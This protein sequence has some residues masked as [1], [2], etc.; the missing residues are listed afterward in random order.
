MVLIPHAIRRSSYTVPLVAAVG[1]VS[2]SAAADI[3]RPPINYTTAT[4]DNC[5]SRLERRIESGQTRLAF[6]EPFGYLPSLLRE[7]EIAPSSQMLVFSKTSF[8][9]QRISPEKPRAVYFNDEAYVGYCQR[10]NVVEVTAVDPQLGAV[11][12]TLEQK[13]A[14]RPRFVRQ[15]DSCLIC[16]ASSA[17]QGFP[18]HLVRSVYADADG[19]PVLSLGSHR[20]N[21]CSPLSERWGGWYVTGA[22]GKQAHLGNLIVNEERQPDRIDNTAGL[23]VTDLSRRFA[24]SKY[25]SPHS[26]IV[27]LMVFEHQTE[28]QNLIARANFLAKLALYE[29]ADLNKAMGRPL[30]QRSES[31]TR[32]LK[33]AAEPLVQYMLFSGESPLT[34]AVHGSSAFAAE[35]EQRG[36]RDG[37]GRSLRALDLQRR[38]F[39]HPCSYLIYSPAFNDLPEPVK[40]VVWRR[41]WDVLVGEDSSKEFIHLTSE[42]RRAIREILSAT[43]PALPAFWKSN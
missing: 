35:F 19:Q 12:Y 2:F 23:N 14:D 24:T 34:E 42:D 25:L 4:V 7:L 38:L 41:L 6:E 20:I 33:N 13:A 37:Q 30:G 39:K 15:N 40:D 43:H 11:F 32:R 9:R 31:T 29:E 16:H 1:L 28:M 18:G 22:S 10:G 26:D 17:N 21:Q 27:T 36:P 5:V 3:E 8:Q